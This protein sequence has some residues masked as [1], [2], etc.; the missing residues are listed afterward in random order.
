MKYTE[1]DFKNARFATHPDGRFAARVDPADSIPWAVSEHDAD[2]GWRNDEEM[3]EGGWVPGLV[4]TETELINAATIRGYD[5]V[6]PD[7]RA[8][9]ARLGLTI[10]PDP[11]PTNADKATAD[12]ETWGISRAGALELGPWLAGQGWTKTPT[13]EE[14]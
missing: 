5:E 7:T 14:S 6:G 11:E 2:S 3:V 9:M 4:A 8:V 13:K 1:N 10:I 12:L